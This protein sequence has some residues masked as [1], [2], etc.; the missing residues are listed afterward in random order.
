MKDTFRR[1]FVV[2]LT[3]LLVSAV[4]CRQ[5]EPEADRLPAGW[6]QWA[7]PERVNLL[8]RK[9]AVASRSYNSV[10]VLAGEIQI[11]ANQDETGVSKPL[12]VDALPFAFSPAGA[13]GIR[14]VKQTRDG[15]LV[16]FNQGEFGG[17]LWFVS[18]DGS[19][20][21]RILKEDVIRFVEVFGRLFVF[22]SAVPLGGQ[23]GSIYEITDDGKIANHLSFDAAP[24]IY[25]QD[26]GSSMVVAGE[27]GVYRVSSAM[28]VEPIVHGGLYGFSPNSIVVMPDKTIYVGLRFFV[29]QLIPRG[30]SYEEQW[31]VSKAC[32]EF[33]VGSDGNNC[34]C[35]AS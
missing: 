25:A 10:S 15:W 14:S 13:G 18:P 1:W 11:T 32:R 34:V 4:S 3:A 28:T 7:T 26:S 35:D 22:T 12:R 33:H 5:K 16:G 31:I 24:E 23:N 17:S 9:C 21:T 2:G 8:A 29:L 20:S 6:V 19:K 27:S 30:H